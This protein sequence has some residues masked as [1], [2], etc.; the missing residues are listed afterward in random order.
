MSTRLR[1]IYLHHSGMAFAGGYA[2][3]HLEAQYEAAV[4][5]KPAR[6]S[7]IEAARIV[8]MYEKLPPNARGGLF[9]F[10]EPRA[11]KTGRSRFKQ[12]CRHWSI[13]PR[14]LLKK[15]VVGVVGNARFRRP[16]APTRAIPGARPRFRAEMRDGRLSVAAISPE[17]PQQNA[18]GGLQGLGGTTANQVGTDF[19]PFIWDQ[20][21]GNVI[22]WT[23]EPVIRQVELAEQRIRET[24]R[25][26]DREWDQD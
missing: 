1:V 6:G 12:L 4:A 10:R 9:L 23:P 26:I 18:F 15:K 8:R 20:Q 2:V 17:P 5:T 7:L 19:G 14:K 24:Q 16:P 13:P 3:A 11:V 22:Q 21:T 25:A